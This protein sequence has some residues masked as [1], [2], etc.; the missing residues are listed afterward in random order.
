MKPL[1]TE[2]G[3]SLLL[4][5]ICGRQNPTASGP[6]LQTGNAENI[7]GKPR[8]RISQ[9]PTV[10]DNSYV[11]SLLLPLFELML[12]YQLTQH[13]PKNWR[14]QKFLPSGSLL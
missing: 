2:P 3:L 7:L 13:S 6:S 10:N 5:V 4:S 11:S 12:Y 14:L 9:M 1:A 8:R